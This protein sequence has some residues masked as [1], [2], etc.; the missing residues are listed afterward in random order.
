MRKRRNLMV[1]SKLFCFAFYFAN[2]MLFIFHPT[3]KFVDAAH[4]GGFMTQNDIEFSQ[5]KSNTRKEWIDNMIAESKK[6]KLEKQRDLEETESK[7][8]DL[9]DA[10]K[11]MMPQLRS[12]GQIYNKKLETDDSGQKA[13]PYDMLVRELGFEKGKHQAQDRLK[14]EEEIVKEEK[15]KLE[16]L[17][18]DRIR[19]MNGE[20]VEECDEP[21]DA[22]FDDDEGSEEENDEEEDEEDESEEETQSDLESDEDD[23][24]QQHQGQRGSHKTA[25]KSTSMADKLPESISDIPFTFSGNEQVVQGCHLMSSTRHTILCETELATNI[26]TLNPSLF[27]IQ[28]QANLKSWRLISRAGLLPNTVSSCSE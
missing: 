26:P 11:T 18:A 9:D 1:K 25:K 5:G 17:E 13:D 27:C 14:T 20:V 10:W 3:A 19:R 24:V 15:A 7:T 4:F 23:K 2:L 28:Y 16:K 22:D 8:R 6:R 21:N 12:S